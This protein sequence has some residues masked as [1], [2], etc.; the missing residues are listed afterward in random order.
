MAAQA[1]ADR[2]SDVP[3]R[4]G[5]NDCVRM[6]AYHLRRLGWRV[7]LPPS[8]AYASLRSARREMAALGFTSLADALDSF[9]FARIAP[10]AAGVGDVIELPGAEEGGLG[11]LTIGMGNGRVLGWH[12]DV[13][14]AVKLQPA[15]W[16]RAWR[17]VPR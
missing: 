4:L 6:V 15:E 1:T 2:F 8:G 10:A 7:K 16:I 12:P 5:R 3:L 14:G 13:R 9:G 11:A 17:V